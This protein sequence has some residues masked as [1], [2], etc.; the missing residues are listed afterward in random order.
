MPS[1]TAVSVSAREYRFPVSPDLIRSLKDP[2]LEGVHIHHAYV[3]VG[4]FPHGKFPDDVNPRSHENP[5]GRIPKLIE[6]SLGERPKWF[7]L[8][9]RG[10]LVIAQK[11]WYDNRSQTFHV[12]IESAETGGLADGATTDRVLANAKKKVSL[13]D[14]ETL[15]E[16]E[17]PEQIKDSFVH[18]EV[19]SG[20]VE[21][22]LVPLTG[23][24]NTSN[25]VKEFALENLGGGFEWL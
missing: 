24:R 20:D 21:E 8:L 17:I 22:M 7:H 12:L 14:F 9:N 5:T 25:Q 10:L 13:A 15:L 1:E 11:A 6:E 4:A 23:A 3:R 2:N 18:V 19:I 16:K